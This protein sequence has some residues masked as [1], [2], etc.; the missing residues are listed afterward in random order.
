LTGILEFS[1]K[2]CRQFILGFLEPKS[3]AVGTP[4]HSFTTG[5]GKLR[6]GGGLVSI[7]R[8]DFEGN[9]QVML[10]AKR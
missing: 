7:C 2:K 8:L 5:P 3:P 1:C 10:Q 6:L 9:V 4:Q